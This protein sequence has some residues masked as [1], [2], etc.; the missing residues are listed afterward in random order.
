ML[1]LNL[2]KTYYFGIREAFLIPNFSEPE[3]TSKVQD[4]F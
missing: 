3:F 2:Q 1:G 4:K